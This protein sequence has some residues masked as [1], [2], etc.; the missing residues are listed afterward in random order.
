MTRNILDILTRLRSNKLFLTAFVGIVL[1]FVTYHMVNQWSEV[2]NLPWRFNGWLLLACFLSFIPIQL[3]RSFSW[4]LLLGLLGAKVKLGQCFYIN[5]LS[6]LARYVPGKAI[7][8]IVFVEMLNDIGISRKRGVVS[9]ILDNAFYLISA[10][11]LFLVSLVFSGRGEY[12]GRFAA[13]WILVPVG[14]ASVHPR[15]LLPTANFFLRLL[16]RS[17][18]CVTYRYRSALVVLSLYM[19]QGIGGGFA[20]WF[21]LRSFYESGISIISITG[22]FSISFAVGLIA[23]FAPAGLVVREGVMVS[24][25]RLQIPLEVAMAFAVLSRAVITLVEFLTGVIA[26]KLIGLDR[27]KGLTSPEGEIADRLIREVRE[28]EDLH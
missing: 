25:L 18:L 8:H 27:K 5:G 22:I 17:P 1:G 15:I 28:G 26:W 21:L 7:G 9:V 24:L 3:I 19:F 12:A 16:K 14:L 2:V 13:L 20:L 23:I 4:K 11:I 6:Q 10:V